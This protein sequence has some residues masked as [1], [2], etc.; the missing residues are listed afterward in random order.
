MVLVL[1]TQSDDKA[2]V[3]IQ[4]PEFFMSLGKLQAFFAPDSLDFLMIDR[5]ALHAKQGRYL[6]VAIAPIPL[7]Q[8][9]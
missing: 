3:V 6:T 5:P 2:I 7:G 4:V 1:W 8:L 9:D